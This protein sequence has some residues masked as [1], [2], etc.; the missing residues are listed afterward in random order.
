MQSIYAI[1]SGSLPELVPGDAEKILK[2]QFGQTLSLLT[3]QVWFLTE[4]ARYAETDSRLRGSKHLPSAEDL[5]VSVK[6]AGNELL[7]RIIESDFY[8]QATAQYKPSL[9]ESNNEWI[10]SVYHKLV[11]SNEYAVYNSEPGRNK[12]QEREI[13]EF[14]YNDLM[15]ANEE[16][17]GFVED[18]FNNWDDDAEMLRMLVL[19]YLQKPGVVKLNEMISKEKFD[20]A[21]ELLEVTETRTEQLEDIIKPKL[22]N[23]DAERLALLDMIL[24][25]MGVA[26][27]LYFDTIPPKVTINEY[28]DLAK[29]YSTPQ[30]GQFINGILDSVR[31][32]LENNNRLNKVAYKK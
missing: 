26:E 25:E 8:K 30:S 4:V 20:F 6:I 29:A 32:E 9:F 13:L 19:Q 16:F 11:A 22:R 28:I 14:I 2:K 5:S 21:K 31:K 23:W 17:V 3:Y 12:K 27:F 10:K 15:L 1:R 24:L 18:L 7:W